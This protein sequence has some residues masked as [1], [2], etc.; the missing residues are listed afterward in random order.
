[1]SMVFWCWH[2]R[3][4]CSIFHE[5]RKEYMKGKCWEKNNLYQNVYNQWW[6]RM[7]RSTVWPKNS[8]FSVCLSPVIKQECLTYF[9][10][11][12]YWH[13]LRNCHRLISKLYAM[14]CPLFCKLHFIHVKNHGY[15]QGVKSSVG[16]ELWW[17]LSDP[18]IKL[19]VWAMCRKFNWAFFYLQVSYQESEMEVFGFVLS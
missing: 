17:N 19:Q 18:P 5:K 16:A 3:R 9:I 6:L 10:R 11:P 2:C 4:C 15:V 14:N 7:I 12:F 8:S 1:M 13:L